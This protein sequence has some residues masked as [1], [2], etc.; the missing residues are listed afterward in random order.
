M[1]LPGASATSNDGWC[2]PILA[3]AM[4]LCCAS[5]PEHLRLLGALR[6]QGVTFGLEQ[7]AAGT[8]RGFAHSLLM[9]APL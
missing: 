9:P 5:W 2:L 1:K 4:P 7:A 6:W 3:L 8:V